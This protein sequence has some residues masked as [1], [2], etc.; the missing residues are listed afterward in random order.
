LVG[1]IGGGLG[2][3]GGATMTCDVTGD[4]RVQEVKVH[5]CVGWMNKRWNSSWSNILLLNS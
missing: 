2:H 1:E 3:G 4:Q 5:R